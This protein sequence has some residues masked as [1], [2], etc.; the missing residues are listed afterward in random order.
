MVLAATEDV[1]QKGMLGS[2]STASNKSA[3]LEPGVILFFAR[4]FTFLERL[5]Y[6]L[7]KG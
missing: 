2:E 1:I 6:P 7:I 3:R 4:P 5:L